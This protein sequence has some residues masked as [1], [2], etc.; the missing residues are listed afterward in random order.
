MA[1]NAL[2]GTISPERVIRLGI[3]IKS[4]LVNSKVKI[5]GDLETLGNSQVPTG[6]SVYPEVIDIKTV[7]AAMLHF[8]RNIIN[9]FPENWLRGSYLRRF[10]KFLRS[11]L[12]PKR[13]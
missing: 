9:H 7:A 8:D 5:I 13:G 11:K 6:D 1:R 12:L 4:E 10:R 2:S 3:Q